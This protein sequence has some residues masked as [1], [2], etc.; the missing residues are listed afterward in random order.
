MIGYL[1]VTLAERF[2]IHVLIPVYRIIEDDTVHDSQMGELYVLQYLPCLCQPHN[3][4]ELKTL[5]VE[6]Q[7]LIQAKIGMTK[8]SAVYNQIRQGAAGLRQE[9]KAARAFLVRHTHM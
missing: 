2:L 6:L 4:E 7:D 9:R 1:P 3:V 8:F 5:S